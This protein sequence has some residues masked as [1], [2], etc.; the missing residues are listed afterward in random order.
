MENKFQLKP[1]DR[2]SIDFAEEERKRVDE[3]GAVVHSNEMAGV[4]HVEVV[5]DATSNDVNINKGLTN[6]LSPNSTYGIDVTK[7]KKLIIYTDCYSTHGTTILDLRVPI[8]NGGYAVSNVIMSAWVSSQYSTLRGTFEVS[9]DKKY[10]SQSLNWYH[11]NNTFSQNSDY[12]VYKIE[13][14]Y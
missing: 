14:V 8:E 10:F 6:G 9:A 3:E 1:S 11:A 4:E 7:Y 2:A 13:G 5:Y 12:K